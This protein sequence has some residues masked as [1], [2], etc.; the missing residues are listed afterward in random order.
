V[1]PTLQPGSSPA[2]DIS[3]Q[4][5]RMPHTTPL[6]VRRAF[7]LALAG[8]LGCG[9]DLVLP[10]TPRTEESIALAKVNGDGQVGTVGDTL[11]RPLVVQVY[12][13]SRHPLPGYRVAFV[14]GDAQTGAITPD[15][16]ETDASG[17]ATAKWV[18]GTTVGAKAVVAHLVGDTSEVQ[19][20]EFTATA[21]A[22]APHTLDPLSVQAQSGRKKQT[23][24]IPP[25]VRVVDRYGNPV[26]GA[27]VS[28]EVG[29]GSG[30]VSE[31]RTPTDA[32]GNA[33]V[34]WTLGSR[35]GIQ[36]LTATV[37]DVGVSPVIFTATVLF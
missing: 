35:I 28:W 37:G 4:R 8:A 27:E 34:E 30:S 12:T 23:V 16:A 19:I 22:A 2:G 36:K 25:Q 13:E 32:D 6:S 5:E 31:A 18:L 17:Q 15:T 33:T 24:N 21:K 29:G 10:D 11:A 14:L 1:G 9:T 20:A 7:V 3:K 26:Q